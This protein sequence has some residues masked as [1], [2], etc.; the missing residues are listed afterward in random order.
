MIGE[1]S[2]WLLW[3]GAIS[4][5]VFVC[6]A[7]AVPFLVSR[8]PEDYFLR[9]PGE[10]SSWRR[11]RPLLHGTLRIGGNVLGLLLLLAGIALLFIPG[12]G[13]LTI[14]AGLTLLEFPGKRRLERA[15]IRR[16]AVLRAINWIRG[17]RGA[18]PLKVP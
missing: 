3:I 4:A 10:R 5:V 11:R 13:I 7:A 6:S 17:R 8:I 18:P 1:S 14:L 12:Q 15:L 2:D 9:K 16:K